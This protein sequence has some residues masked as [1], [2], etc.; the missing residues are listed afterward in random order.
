MHRRLLAWLLLAVFLSAGT[1]LPG[2]DAL[3]HHWRAPA[4]EQRTHVEPAG[5]CG[6]HAEK[7]TLGRTATG[8]GAAIVQSPVLRTQPFGNP[9]ASVSRTVEILVADLDAIPHSRA[10]PASA[11]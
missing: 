7:C 9:S 2:T 8:A 5:G 4:D 6:A 3:L 11:A 1:T 10:P